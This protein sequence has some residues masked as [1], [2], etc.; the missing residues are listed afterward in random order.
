MLKRL[1]FGQIYLLLAVLLAASMVASAAIGV[2]MY[3]PGQMARD[4]VHAFGWSGL[5]PAEELSSGIFLSLRLPRVLLAALTGAVLGVSGTLMQGLF[6]N[7][8]VE[9]GLVGTSAGAALGAALMIVVGGNVSRDL[10]S[11]LGSF[12]LPVVAFAFSFAAT[13]FVYRISVRSG[14]V[15]VFTMLLGGIA[16]N[17]VCAAGIGFLAFNSSDPQARTITAWQLGTFTGAEWHGTTVVAVAFALCFAW[18]LRHGKSLNALMLGEDEASYL[19]IQPRRLIV[20]LIVINTLMV[21]IDTAMVGV[22]AF[23]GLVIPHALRMLKSA[24][25]TFLLPG[26]ALLGAFSMEVIDI[27]ARTLVRPTEISVGIITAI[28]GAPVFLWILVSQQRKGTAGF[29]G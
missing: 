1:S 13:M 4:L 23:I 10:V 21:A 28:V 29:Y 2:N 5:D 8:I 20:T 15:N 11:H 27:V 12:G 3:T 18:S 7:P 6:R 19:G 22:I 26:S 16:I 14:K 25:Y 9:P 17:A 24:D